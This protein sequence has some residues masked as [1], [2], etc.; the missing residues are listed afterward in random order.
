MKVETISENHVDMQLRMFTNEEFGK[1]RTVIING[2][3]WFVGKDVAEAL[4]YSNPQKALRD[5]VDSDDRTVNESFTV[6]GTAV[7]LINESG[8]YSLI[9]LSKLL[10]AKKF[11]RWVTSEVLPSLRKYGYYY[12][13]NKYNNLKDIAE[14]QFLLKKDTYKYSEK[15]LNVWQCCV[16]NN[17]IE[18]IIQVSGFKNNFVLSKIYDK[19]YKLY[20]FD[21]LQAVKD[22]SEKHGDEFE[23]CTYL[24]AVADDA[25]YREMFM[26][27]AN[28][29]LQD[30]KKRKQIIAKYFNEE[31]KE[32]VE[33]DCYGN[34]IL[35][36]YLSEEDYMSLIL[37]V[38]KQIG[39][40]SST[41][42][43]TSKYIYNKMYD[44]DGWTIIQACWHCSSKKALVTSVCRYAERFIEVCQNS[45]SGE[46][47]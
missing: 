9:M 14:R 8:L 42:L 7:I 10:S 37:N 4:G 32:N 12:T 5:H 2:E 39:D 28:E 23:R 16:A 19:M 43:K 30:C 47:M 40:N 6:N 15:D 36:Q 35:F 33:L 3:V 17:A 27:S 46:T 11:K 22:F 45:S 13:D 38:S 18:K 20:G 24:M 29:V 44:H 31:E 34:P 25:N 26:R 41:K 21:S 1:V